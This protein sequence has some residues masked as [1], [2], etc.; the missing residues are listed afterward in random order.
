[1][2]KSLSLWIHVVLSVAGRAMLW[3]RADALW[4]RT[5]VFDESKG[6]REGERERWTRRGRLKPLFAWNHPPGSVLIR[7]YPIGYGLAAFY[8]KSKV[9]SCPRMVSSRNREA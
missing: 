8:R 7:R 2:K 5:A 3:K 6:R 4:T 1:M 9:S